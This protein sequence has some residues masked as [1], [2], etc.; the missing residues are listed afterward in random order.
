MRRLSRGN[1]VAR[2]FELHVE[3][4]TF[5]EAAKPELAVHFQNGEFIPR[6][7]YLVDIYQALNQL[8][9]KMKQKDIIQCAHFSNAFVEKLCNWKRKVGKVS[10]T[11]I[12]VSHVCVS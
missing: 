12:T 8:N 5:L 9:L 11:C 7:A 3:V 10:L 1:V 6:R 4:K 2:V